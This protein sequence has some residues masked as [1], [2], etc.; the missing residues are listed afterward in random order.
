MMEIYLHVPI[1]YNGVV[2]KQINN[3]TLASVV[4]QS[5]KQCVKWNRNIINGSWP[6][7]EEDNIPV[8]AWKL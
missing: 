4:R 7:F 3:F 5:P 6:F 2:L 1:H 8:F